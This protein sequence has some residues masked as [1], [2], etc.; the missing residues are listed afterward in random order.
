MLTSGDV[1]SLV[2]DSLGDEA[3][4][5]NETVTCFYFDFA[6]QKDQSP[7]STMGALLKQVV[8]GLEEIPEEISQAY[9]KQRKVLGGREPR[10]SDIVKMLQ[11][12]TS[13]G[14]TFICIDALDECVP[15]YRAKLLD[16]LSKILQNSPG[17]RIFVTGRPHIRPEIGRRLVGKVTSV[18]ISTKRDDIITYLRSRLEDDTTPDAMD[19]SLEADILRKIPEDVS[20]MY[21]ETAILWKLPQAFTDKYT[22]RFLLVSLNIDA[23]LEETTIHRRRQKLGAMTDGL[24]LGD[25]Y[26]ATLGRIKRQ[27]GEKARLGMATL[28][29]ISH[30]ERPLKTSELC[31][32]LAVEI[33]SLNLNTDNVP[34]INTLLACCQGLI[35]VEKEA[36]TV[37][38]IH[39]TLQEYLR[40]HPDLFTAA[41]AVM[42]ETCLSYLN[43]QE[44]KACST[45]PSPGLQVTPFLEY[46]SV[47]WGVH[48]KRD[49]SDSAKLLVLKLFDD[50]NRHISTKILIKGQ[51]MSGVDVDRFSGFSGLHCASFFGIVEIVAVLIQMGC[52]DINQTDS[53]G[54]TPLIWAARNGHKGVVK[55]LL[56]RD[57][58]NPD[59]QDNDGRTPFWI[60][61][62]EG[63][64]GVVNI[65]LGRDDVNPDKPDNNGQT[66]LWRA[67]FNGHDG[68]VNIL[69]GRDD[70]NP[71]KPD[72]YGET[73]LRWATKNGREGVVKMLLGRDDVNPNKRDNHG[74]TPLWWAAYHGH[75]GVV[76]I[77][78][79]R[80][81]VN[82]DKP[83]KKG[84]TPLW[85][86]AS[87]G[88]EGVVEILLERDDVSPDKPN[89]NGRT[90]LW[91]AARDGYEGVVK[92]L[93]ARDDVSPNKP[94]IYGETPLF[95]ALKKRHKGVIAL[96]Q[97]SEST[98]PSMS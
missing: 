66:P 80:D 26:G 64:E 63:H 53:R 39:F 46:S 88:H 25:A 8:G 83:D 52:C 68:V 40:A 36:S 78:L 20:E 76:E 12:T 22:S 58:V 89:I 77:L 35:M 62:T 71:D 70:V 94:D 74:R 49:L 28:M 47:Y 33:G 97:P 43:S 7:T 3:G 16:S 48:A 6:D 23:I 87:E 81:D 37:R 10:L 96:L 29:W 57:D 45:G 11:T 42:A 50:Y 54:N 90:P 72:I 98:A 44:V 13:K 51:N 85:N 86:A 15:E 95:W 38:L 14:R 67:A 5:Q 73:P 92:M 61:A 32:A 79:E 24:G 2:I 19:S 65:L 82:P 21:V 9:Q 69:L 41:H 59:K 56:E 18:P 91:W 4:E 60:A 27:G 55:I 30:S 75:E 93:L 1:S 34:S 17:S 31:H 84:R